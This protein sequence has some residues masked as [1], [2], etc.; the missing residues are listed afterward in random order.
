MRLKMK[1]LRQLQQT[2]LRPSPAIRNSHLPSRPP[3]I[4]SQ[5]WSAGTHRISSQ[6]QSHQEWSAFGDSTGRFANRNALRQIFVR[7][8]Y[9]HA[10]DT[11]ICR[12]C[13]RR[14]REGVICL[15]FHNRPNHDASCQEDLFKQRE[16]HQEIRIN[17]VACLIVW[18]RVASARYLSHGD[19]AR[20]LARKS[21]EYAMNREI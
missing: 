6:W 17:T 11:L 7:R 10:I 18:R 13:D 19:T 5:E 2:I 15:E 14:S 9:D 8:A 16:L 20:R 4:D 12:R 3:A 21:R 1:K